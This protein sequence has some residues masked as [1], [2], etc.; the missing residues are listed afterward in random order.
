M[1]GNDHR[2]RFGRAADQDCH[3]RKTGIHAEDLKIKGHAIELRVYAEDPYENFVPSINILEK[4]RLPEGE[5]IRVDNG[6]REGDQ[7]PI[8]YDPMLAKLTAHATTRK[9]ALKNISPLA[10]MK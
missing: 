7:V 1:T 2:S 4:Y 10:N 8:Y 3:G 9:A 5:G 6:Y